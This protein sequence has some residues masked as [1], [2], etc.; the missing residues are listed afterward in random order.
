MADSLKTK[1]PRNAILVPW[2]FIT[3]ISSMGSQLLE[4]TGCLIIIIEHF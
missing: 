1:P 3:E 4:M 2:A